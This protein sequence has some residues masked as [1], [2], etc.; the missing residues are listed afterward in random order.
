MGNKEFKIRIEKIAGLAG[1]FELF[2][3]AND[4]TPQEV[5]L[6]CRL[7]AIFHEVV[8]GASWHDELVV[9][10]EF[11]AMMMEDKSSQGDPDL[12]GPPR[13]DSLN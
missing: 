5:Y 11:I 3:M 13:G 4:W 12:S 10:S 1:E 8:N 2:A 9:R 6:V 7:L